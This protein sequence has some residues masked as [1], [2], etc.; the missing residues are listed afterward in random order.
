MVRVQCDERF[1]GEESE[2]LA[3]EFID[4]GG[5]VV[6]FWYEGTAPE[7][8]IV[9]VE[10]VDDTI[11]DVRIRLS[12]TAA[13][14]SYELAVWRNYNAGHSQHGSCEDSAR[15]SAKLAVF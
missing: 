10:V 11:L 13:T 14:G 2:A 5:D 15:A 3:V 4:P 9:S 7:D 1:A 12:P 6:G 8:A